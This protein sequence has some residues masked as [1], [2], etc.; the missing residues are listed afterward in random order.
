MVAPFAV[1]DSAPMDQGSGVINP[2]V[3]MPM[4]G[5]GV[6][7]PGEQ[8]P[9]RGGLERRMAAAAVAGAQYGGAF[10]GAMPGC[11]PRP[12]R[13]PGFYV[14][15]N[16]LYEASTADINVMQEPVYL[17]SLYVVLSATAGGTGPRRVRVWDTAKSTA[18]VVAVTTDLLILQSS[19]VVVGGMFY[20][21]PSPT[22]MDCLVVAP[23]A[24]S[25]IF[26]L[27][28]R[29]AAGLRVQVV[30]EGNSYAVLAAS[31]LRIYATF[32]AGT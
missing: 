16:G 17:T 19:E 26:P 11:D 29:F 23:N 15:R 6:I 31:T 4:Q 30:D 12:D 1:V 25:Q 21:E 18:S 3:Q 27:G 22:T 28:P 13:R 24:Y 10:V 20:W 7:K 8:M 14:T 9:M 2:G 32:I 5:S